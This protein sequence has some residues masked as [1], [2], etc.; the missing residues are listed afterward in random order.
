[1]LAERVYAPWIDMAAAL[2]AAHRPLFS[3]ESRRPLRDF[4]VIGFSLGYELTYTN[5]LNMLDLAQIPVLASERDDSYPLVIAGGTTALNPE[6]MTDFVDLFVIGDGEEVV[7]ELMSAIREWK[8]AGGQRGPKKGLLLEAAKIPG[9]YVPG[10]YH[11]EYQS[12]GRFHS[13][14]PGAG[15]ARSTIQQRLVSQLPPPPTR[16]VV[17]YIEVVHD[18]A[19]IE[20]QRGCSR[21]CRFCQAG[22]IYRPVRE[23]PQA[24]VVQAV[25][26]LITNCGYTEASLVSLS[27]SDYP[28]VEKLVAELSQRYSEHNLSLSLPSLRIDSFSLQLME[29]LPTHRKTGLTFAPEAGSERLR[30]TI[31]KNTSDEA[32]LATAAAAF[33]RGWVNLKLYFMLGLPTETDDDVIA[34]IHLLDR[35]HALGSKAPG[36]RPQLRVSLSTFVPKPHTPFQWAAQEKEEI[37]N[38]RQELLNREARRKGIKLSWQDPKVSLLEATLSRGDRRL[39]KVIHHTWQMG[40]TFDAWSDRFKYDNWLAAFG[41]AGLEPGFYAHRERPFDEPLPWNHIQV[42]VTAAFLKREYERAQAGIETHDCRYQS[43][44]ACGLERSQPACQQKRAAV[45]D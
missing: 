12:D 31:N 39:G 45:K 3:L 17:P 24:E 15:P 11:V 5:V 6:P 9:I 44:N 2:R 33:E 25:G 16:P 32:L 8:T 30:R 28:G 22:A 10:L 34:I 37:L 36:R 40:S 43:C 1:V 35:V 27:T 23:R 4:D 13:L 20:I 26:E 29:A 19:A 21:G 18:R 42:G 14:T 41:E 7:L 38:T